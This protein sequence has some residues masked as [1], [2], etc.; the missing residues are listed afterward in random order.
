MIN[1]MLFRVLNVCS[2][3]TVFIV[4][5]AIAKTHVYMQGSGLLTGSVHKKDERR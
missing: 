1:L 4:I 5:G 3:G 2:P